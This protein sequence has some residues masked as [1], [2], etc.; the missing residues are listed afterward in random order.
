M[1]SYFS[2]TNACIQILEKKINALGQKTKKL[3]GQ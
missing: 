3:K 2:H 1:V